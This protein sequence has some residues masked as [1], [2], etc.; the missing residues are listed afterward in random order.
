MYR[1]GMEVLLHLPPA[2]VRDFFHG[3]FQLP[4]AR[5]QAYMAGTASVGEISAI[6]MQVFTRVPAPLKARLMG[7]SFTGHGARMWGTLL[8][9]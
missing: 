9:G 6:M 7:Q 8:G 3:F 5:W 1:F 2:D 4:A